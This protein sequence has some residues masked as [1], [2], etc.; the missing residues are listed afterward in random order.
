MWYYPAWENA[1][2]MCGTPPTPRSYRNSLAWN[3]GGFASEATPRACG[4]STDFDQEFTGG[5]QNRPGSLLMLLP[6]SKGFVEVEERPNPSTQ[7]VLTRDGRPTS[8]IG[9]G[10]AGP[11]RPRLLRS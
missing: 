6:A 3:L 4:A 7:V 2:L 1:L 5:K 10:D 9:A 11:V 8:A